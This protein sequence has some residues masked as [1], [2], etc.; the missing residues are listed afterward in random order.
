MNAV[1]DNATQRRYELQTDAGLAFI[2]YR[3]VDRIV[4]MTHAEVPPQLQGHGIGSALVQGALELVR[5]Q[6][7]KV[8]PRCPFIA[9]YI[10]RHTEFQE[11][12][13]E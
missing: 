3:R 13:A 5:A 11:L 12:L 8:I 1:T 6:Q 4:T 2:N 10:T 9:I 7:E